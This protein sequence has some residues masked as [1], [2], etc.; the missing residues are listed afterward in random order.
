M[1]EMKEIIARKDVLSLYGKFVELVPGY[2]CSGLRENSSDTRSEDTSADMD[3]SSS[4]AKR[5]VANR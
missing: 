4:T 2:T 1:E 5:V 3:F